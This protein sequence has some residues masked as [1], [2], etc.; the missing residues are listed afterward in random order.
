MKVKE[1][2]TEWN[3]QFWI[4]GALTVIAT[5]LRLYHIGFNSL[6]LDEA[7]TYSLSVVPIDQIWVNMATGE[8]NP[9]LFFLI[10]HFMLMIANNEIALRFMPAMF[11]IAAV[12]VIYLAGKEFCDKYVG[13]IAAA[14]FTFS[15]FLLVYSQEARAYTLLLLL[16]AAMLLFFLKGLKNVDIK[17]WMAFAAIA[18]LAVW[19]HFYSVVFIVALFSYAALK[20]QAYRERLVQ[21]GVIVTLLSLP[22]IM[23]LVNL[24]AM[25]T[26][27][28]PTYGIQ[29]LALVAETFKQI[30]GYSDILTLI[31]V[32]LLLV[33]LAWAYENAYG[34]M[35]LVV[36]LITISIGVS[37]FLSLIIPMLPRYMIFLTIPFYLG[38][39]M[40]YR[41][42]RDAISRLGITGVESA[43]IVVWFIVMFGMIGAPFYLSYYNNLTKENWR[44]IASDLTGMTQDGDVVIAVP[45]YIKLP[46]GY[47]Y[48]STADKTAFNGLS[49]VEGLELA[50]QAIPNTT[51]YV[52]TP[53]LAAV[54]PKGTVIGWL[55]ENSNI[56]A[57][58]DR[59]I[60]ARRVA[61]V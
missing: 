16:C 44:G 20:S 55:A 3:G 58:Y 46:L 24:I 36:W 45:N 5:I 49:T 34:N 9:P 35:A 22:I 21:S 14:A 53:D 57:R 30:S 51:Y 1:E 54:D 40:S 7:A 31:M 32:V 18:G 15:P 8:F 27:T 13:M 19:T 41:P 28:A 37:L 26:K 23:E 33:G 38:I 17:N 12:P 52:V 10:E 25:R 50:K 42:I 43:Y 59:V 39:G 61:D 29:G 56:I 60:I 6:W 11:G 47:Y 2:R 48:N 4:V